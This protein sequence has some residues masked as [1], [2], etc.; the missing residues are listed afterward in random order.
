VISCFSLYS[1]F[2]WAGSVPTVVGLPRFWFG[3]DSCH[4]VSQ[5]EVETGRWGTS[6]LWVV[7]PGH[8]LLAD[9]GNDHLVAS[10]WIGH[11]LPF[12]LWRLILVWLNL[13]GVFLRRVALI[14]CIEVFVSASIC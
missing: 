4:G 2:F 6:Y 11:C 12:F 3:T 10:D 9:V 8:V 14:L 7:C 1:G 13:R 5:E